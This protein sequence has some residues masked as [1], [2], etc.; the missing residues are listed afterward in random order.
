ML[1]NQPSLKA[2]LRRSGGS[3]T[4]KYAVK[5]LGTI[6]LRYL[7]KSSM[8]KKGSLTNLDVALSVVQLKSTY[9]KPRWWWLW[10][11]RTPNIPSCLRYLWKIYDGSFPSDLFCC[12]M[13]ILTT[14][15]RPI[16]LVM[17]TVNFFLYDL[18]E[19]QINLACN[20]ICVYTYINIEC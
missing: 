12:F 18:F 16:Y 20:L 4:P 5:G 2:K 9:L 3:A 10:P 8:L 14:V 11:S 15:R 1:N 19:I 13:A 7:N 17:H 6:Y